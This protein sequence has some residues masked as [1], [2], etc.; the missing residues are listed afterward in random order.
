MR[1]NTKI[2]YGLRTIIEIANAS[3][4][5]GILQKDI[6]KNQ[7][8]SLKYLDPIISALKLK[9]LIVNLKGKGSGY[10]LTRPPQEITLYD[11]YSAFE[12][13]EVVDCVSIP[14]FCDS[15]NEICKSHS[16]WITFKNDFEAIL[17]NRTLKDVLEESYAEI[18]HL[19]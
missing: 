7:N 11:I 15:C 14:K 10:I 16:F 5:E 13:V 17:K 18:I 3:I 2:R 8:L 12:N 6:A 19:S 1:I 9:N 4:L